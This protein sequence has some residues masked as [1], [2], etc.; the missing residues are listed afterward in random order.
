M[1][2]LGRGAFGKTVRMKNKNNSLHGP[3]YAV[4]VFSM[5]DLKKAELTEEDVSSEFGKLMG[6]CHPNVIRYVGTYKIRKDTYIVMDLAS[7]GSLV[8]V[9]ASKPPPQRIIHIMI[10][11][12]SALDYIHGLGL[13][14]RD[15]KPDNILLCSK[16][17]IKL[18]DFNLSG[19]ASSGS[20]RTL[21]RVG[22]PAYFSPERATGRTYGSQDD[23][24]ASACV[25]LELG[26]GTRLKQAV[27][28]DGRQVRACRE[29]LIKEVTE[30]S[31]LLGSVVRMMLAFDQFKRCTAVQAMTA[32][33]AAAVQVRVCVRVSFV[34][35]ITLRE[36]IIECISA[37]CSC[38]PEPKS[39]SEAGL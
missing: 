29:K 4:K 3:M 15:L 25:L 20:S 16:G 19:A 14:H 35:M 8:E 39:D 2:E 11:L 34:A 12:L 22:A 7:G 1:S 31:G 5:R 33:D 37:T 32:L 36:F 6:I 26:T 27:C 17:V 30:L 28:F 9:I 21:T 38:L 24:W 23:V 13:Q 10:D 18:A